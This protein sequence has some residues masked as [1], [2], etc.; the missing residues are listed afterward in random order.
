MIGFPTFCNTCR[1]ES[2]VSC[3]VVD[4]ALCVR[5]LCVE[6]F[7][8]SPCVSVSL[9][10]SPSPSPSPS[11]TLFTCTESE[12]AWSVFAH[13]LAV[14]AALGRLWQASSGLGPSPSPELAYTPSPCDY[15]VREGSEWFTFTEG[16]KE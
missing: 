6:R 2:S 12:G 11:S 14:G 4:V 13:D 9:V 15:V 8:W 5:G 7:V 3:V 1:R 16:E 10:P